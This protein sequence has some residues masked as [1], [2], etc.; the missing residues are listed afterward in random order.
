MIQVRNSDM[1]REV[2]ELA[3]AADRVGG[4]AGRL[5]SCINWSFLDLRNDKASTEYV[6]P[7]G[8]GSSP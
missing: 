6:L 1:L 5:A 4:I 3:Q 8:Q 7:E 2:R